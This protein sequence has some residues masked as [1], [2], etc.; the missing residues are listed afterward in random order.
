MSRGLGDHCP[1]SCPSR[2]P[3]VGSRRTPFSVHSAMGKSWSPASTSV[4][5]VPH[6]GPSL[7]LSLSLLPSLVLPFAC[8]LAAQLPLSLQA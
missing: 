6:S 3:W 5:W 7:L 2:K 1:C 8:L 4:L